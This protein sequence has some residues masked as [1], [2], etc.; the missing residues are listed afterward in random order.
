MSNCIVYAACKMT[1][2]NQLE[3]VERAK[4][5]KSIFAQY[6][7]TVI[8]PV[9][10]E[11]VKNEN[12][13]LIQSSEEQLA[14]FWKRDKQIIAYISHVVFCDEAERKSI[15]MEREYGFSRFGLWKPTCILL[16]V[17]GPTVAGFEDDYVA[18]S[19]H[20]AAHIIQTRWGTRR[21]RIVWRLKMLAR[22][23]PLFLWRQIYAF[24]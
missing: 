14:G 9:I 15:G 7:L 5:V 24:R 6:Q 23:L 4:L 17:G 16:P 8:S 1:G 12:Q 13:T 11:G 19:L 3:M 18:R 21:K 10:E 22:T 2:R 20:E